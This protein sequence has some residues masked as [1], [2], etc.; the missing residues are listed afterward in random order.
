[1]NKPVSIK[2]L[3]DVVAECFRDGKEGGWELQLWWSSSR[4][5]RR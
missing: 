2:K 3:R 5:S 4:N 1:M